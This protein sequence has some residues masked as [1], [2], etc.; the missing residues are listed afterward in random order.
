MEYLD[1]GFHIIWSYDFQYTPQNIG[2]IKSHPLCILVLIDH[3]GSCLLLPSRRHDI[4]WT[5]WEDFKSI[6]WASA[7]FYSLNRCQWN[8]D[9]GKIY[10]E[11]IWQFHC[12]QNFSYL[13]KHMSECVQYAGI[14][15]RTR[16]ASERRRYILAS[17][18]I[19]WAYA[20][21]DSWVWVMNNNWD[22]FSI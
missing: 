17:S 15:L 19:G 3:Q 5:D 9:I 10:L 6:S 16:P 18:H 1:I 13:W 2:M 14:M 11:N 8:F 21:N 12:L 20:Q 22:Y 7:L 4:C